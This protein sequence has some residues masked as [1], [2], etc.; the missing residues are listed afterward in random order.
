MKWFFA[1]F[2]SLSFVFLAVFGVQC[3]YG[4]IFPIKFQE[5]VKNACETYDVNEAVV[6]SMINIESHFKPNVV[7]SKGAVGLM[8][9]MPTTAKSVTEKSDFLN[10]DLF[11]PQDNILLGTCYISE[12]LDRFQNLET[13]LVA[14]NAGPTNVSNWLKNGKYSQDGKVLTEIPF[15]ESKQYLEK[16]RKS[17]AYY[18]IKIKG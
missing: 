13:A 10:F 5:E 1:I 2:F 3:I 12:L 15:K 9:I 6:F 16:F 8:Q 14:Y 4:Y 7:S 11:S 17:Y 18:K